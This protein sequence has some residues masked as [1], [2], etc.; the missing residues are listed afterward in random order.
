MIMSGNL[1]AGSRNRYLLHSMAE[2]G[3]ETKIAPRYKRRTNRPGHS[4]RV[5]S[6]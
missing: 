5:I 1:L 3:Q 2:T 6:G 4:V